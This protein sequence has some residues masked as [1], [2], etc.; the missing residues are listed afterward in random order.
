[1]GIAAFGNPQICLETATITHWVSCSNSSIH[2]VAGRD[3]WIITEALAT[4]LVALEQLPP[5]HQP[6]SNIDDIRELL[7]SLVPS[8]VSL[9]L[10]RAKIRLFPDLDPLA[11]YSEYGLG[12][13]DDQS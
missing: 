9:H 1:L 3:G 12:T 8:T 10:A 4:A 2:K 7:A 5:Q 6:H 11:V 13:P